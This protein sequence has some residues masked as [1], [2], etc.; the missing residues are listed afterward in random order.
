[1]LSS[2]ALSLRDFACV[3]EG[4]NT[5]R[6]INFRR[7]SPV[8]TLDNSG[9]LKMYC[10]SQ[11][12]SIFPKLLWIHLLH[13]HKAK[14]WRL[15]ADSWYLPD[16]I[17]NKIHGRWLVNWKNGYY[18]SCI[19]NK[20]CDAAISTG[21]SY[22]LLA[23]PH[24]KKISFLKHLVLLYITKLN[25]SQELS[26]WS[27]CLPDLLLFCPSGSFSNQYTWKYLFH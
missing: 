1:M 14:S 9:T 18:C 21:L 27:I 4:L 19:F 16:I 22:E 6:S 10:S 3:P 24:E 25:H 26:L 8:G 2:D 17:K 11:M 15:I 12:T 7:Q 20:V 13:C 23:P 5:G